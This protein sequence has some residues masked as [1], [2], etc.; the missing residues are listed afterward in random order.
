M[1]IGHKSL[2]AQVFRRLQM[3]SSTL[4]IALFALSLSSAMSSEVSAQ[5]ATTPIR[6]TWIASSC[7]SWNCAAAELIL[8]DGEP[9]VLV[10]PTD[11]EETPWLVLRRVE[12][13]S[14]YIPETEA[15]G[16]EVFTET[17]T[18]MSAY[19]AMDTCRLP[20]ALTTPDGRML[21]VSLKECG[22]KTRRRAVR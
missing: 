1:P 5:E 4:A 17:A 3:K 9:N 2:K 22:T 16:C 11:L 21:V 15:F 12:E 18:A 19:T 8:A 14:I 20:M 10:M 6:Y 13:G 7:A